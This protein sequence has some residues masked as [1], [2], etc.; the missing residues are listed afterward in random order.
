MAKKL[1]RV[2]DEDNNYCSVESNAS[3]KC[4]SK[5]GYNRDACEAYFTAYKD[6]KKEF[7]ALKSERRRQGLIPNPPPEEMVVYKLQRKQR[8]AGVYV[9]EVNTNNNTQD[10]DSVR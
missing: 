6:C 3:M 2:S 4:L 9:D 1:T 7:N 10:E 5:S 8:L